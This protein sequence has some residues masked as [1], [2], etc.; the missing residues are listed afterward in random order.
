[1]TR[2]RVVRVHATGAGHVTRRDA[3]RVRDETSG[4]GPG[5]SGRRD[6]VGTGR[7]TSHNIPGGYPCHS[8]VSTELKQRS[9][10][11]SQTCTVQAALLVWADPH[12][13]SKNVNHCSC[14][15]Q[16]RKCRI[17]HSYSG[18]DERPV[19]FGHESTGCPSYVVE[20]LLGLR[21]PTFFH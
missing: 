3:E 20:T 16:L 13:F 17:L 14:F 1:M 8:L 9:C 4:I 21:L 12:P 2:S 10:S 5:S 15:L 11:A 19:L 18:V 6:G 7:G